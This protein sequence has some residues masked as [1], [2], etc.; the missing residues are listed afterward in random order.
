MTDNL[1]VR[2]VTQKRKL[3]DFL[4]AKG[5]AEFTLEA[6]SFV[7]GIKEGSIASRLRDLRTENYVVARRELRPGVHGYTVTA[8]L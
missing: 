6:A 3:L 8:P 7:T 4:A 5:G 1:P 2:R